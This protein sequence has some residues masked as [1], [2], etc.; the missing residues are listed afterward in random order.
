MCNLVEYLTLVKYCPPRV[1]LSYA[2]PHDTLKSISPLHAACFQNPNPRVLSSNRSTHSTSKVQKPFAVVVHALVHEG[3]QALEEGMSNVH[4]LGELQRGLEVILRGLD[5][6]MV[7]RA[8]RALG[9]LVPVEEILGELLPQRP[10]GRVLHSEARLARETALGAHLSAK[11]CEHRGNVRLVR[12]SGVG[13][14]GRPD[15]PSTAQLGEGDLSGSRVVVC[16]FFPARAGISPLGAPDR[17][18]GAILLRTCG[19]SCVRR[20]GAGNFEF[21]SA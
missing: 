21:P 4:R 20:S 10:V 1:E 17:R 8:L 9:F 2:Q 7:A 18:P 13:S 16:G 19:P 11:Q 14:P 12:R 3:V 5:A 15:D 6:E